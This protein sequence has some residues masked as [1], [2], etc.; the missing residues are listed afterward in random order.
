[1]P[2]AVRADARSTQDAHR[3][4]VEAGCRRIVESAKSGSSAPVLQVPSPASS[5]WG[6]RARGAPAVS[7]GAESVSSAAPAGCLWTTGTQAMS[8]LVLMRLLPK[9]PPIQP[10][11]THQVLMAALFH[12][13]ARIKDDDEISSPDGGQSMAHVDGGRVADPFDQRVKQ[14]PF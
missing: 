10:I 12:D 9:Q 3:T 13:G 6:T 8:W 11:I 2:T 7:A 5:P 14:P 4:G 1:T